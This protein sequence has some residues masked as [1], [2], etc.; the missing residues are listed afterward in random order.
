MKMHIRIHAKF[1]DIVHDVRR[2]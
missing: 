1:S 2:M